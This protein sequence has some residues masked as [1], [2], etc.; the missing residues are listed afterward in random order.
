[1]V[2][3]GQSKAGLTRSSALPRL[4]LHDLLTA[5]AEHVC[6]PGK[7]RTLARVMMHA[8]HAPVHVMDEEL[9]L[10]CFTLFTHALIYPAF[11]LNYSLCLVTTAPVT[12]TRCLTR[13]IRT[14]TVHTPR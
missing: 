9:L 6:R 14:R 10:S 4:G 7:L 1:M 8:L 12:R 3:D 2:G 11:S 13:L 5:S